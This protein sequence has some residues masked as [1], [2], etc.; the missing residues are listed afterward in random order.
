MNLFTPAE[1]I[2]NYIGTGEAK[3]NNKVSK[4]FFLAILSGMFI[5]F[6]AASSTTAAHSVANVGLARLISG[7]VFPVGLM[8]VVLLGAELFTGNMLISISVCCRRI[9]LMRMIRCLV[10]V[11]VG[12]FVGSLVLALI[13]AYSGQLNYSAS[14][15]AVY[16]MSIA[17]NKCS[18]SFVQALLSGI[19]CNILVCGA[20][21]MC[22]AAKDVAGKVLAAFFPIMAFVVAGFEHSVA[23]MYY[24][25]LGLIA[26]TIQQYSDAA[27][28]AEKT[29]PALSWGNMLLKN[30]LPVTIGNIIGGLFIAIL[31]WYG[32]SKKAEKSA[33]SAKR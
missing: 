11:Y 33:V 21:L 15:L 18:L 32:F 8:M 26:K 9:R 2:S 29:F 31:L 20:V 28:A 1:V 10:I 24:I 19:A 27:T 23:N 7:A 13:V 22:L 14:A 3:A 30:L 12:N 17:N 5:G 25:T 16:A 6:G 4:M